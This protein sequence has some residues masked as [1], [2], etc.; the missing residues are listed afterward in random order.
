[1]TGTQ[2]VTA[3]DLMR[4]VLKAQDIAAEARS[5]ALTRAD[6]EAA[7]AA[8][9]RAAIHAAVSDP[10]LWSAAIEA[11]QARANREAGRWLFGGLRAFASKVAWFVVIGSAVY[12]LGGWAA[13]ANFVKGPGS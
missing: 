8:G 6:L 10:A 11:I 4:E 7:V 3:T 1:M 5:E 13:L 2:E 9:T 12:M